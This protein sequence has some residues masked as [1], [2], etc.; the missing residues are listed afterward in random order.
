MPS[1]DPDRAIYERLFHH[2]P[3]AVS[4]LMQRHGG[5]LALVIGNCLGDGTREDVE[6]VLGELL[7]ALW[8]DIAEYDSRRARFKTWVVMRA[9]YCALAWR[10]KHG[11]IDARCSPLSPDEIALPEPDVLLRVD[12]ALALMD[13]DEL[14]REIVYRCDYLEQ[15]HRQVARDLGMR[16]GALNMRLQRIRRRL[17][18]VLRGWEIPR[19]VRDG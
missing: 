16:C 17:R 5:L 1:G 7:L 8:R 10:R 12:L 11:Q 3:E 14:D 9:R 18:K 15:D 19:E 2:D 4:V 13:L 6:D